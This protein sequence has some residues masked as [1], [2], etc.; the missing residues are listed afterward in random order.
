MAGRVTGPPRT[1][2]EKTRA[3]G[4]PG[5]RAGM[6]KDAPIVMPGQRT[7]PKP[8]RSL[9]KDG[10][11][12]WDRAWSLAH[13]WLSPQT[14]LDL[15]L[16]TCEALDEREALRKLVMAGD[17][18]RFDRGALRALDKQIVDSLGSLGMT[19][20]DRARLGVAEVKIEDDLEAF[21]REQGIG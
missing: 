1:P 10:K 20:T 7:P 15:L 9:G 16:L 6:D 11:Q 19:P 21:R 2:R 8:P 12:L 14:D 18:D 13:T 17:A 5:H 4:N 3:L